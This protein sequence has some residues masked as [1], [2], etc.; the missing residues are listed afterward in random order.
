MAYKKIG[1]IGAMRNEIEILH[2]RMETAREETIA[3]MTFYDG[4]MGKDEDR[5]CGERHR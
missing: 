2:A 3:G 1:V 5:T 4:M